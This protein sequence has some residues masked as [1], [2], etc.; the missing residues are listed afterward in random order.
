MS[1]ENWYRESAKEV[2]SLIMGGRK[3]PINKNAKDL[4][5]GEMGLLN[6]LAWNK[7]EFT[8]GKLSRYTGVGTG[9][10]ANL[11]NS[12]EKKGCVER[13][14][15]PEDRRSV[16]VSITDTGRAL[17]KEKQE[18][19]LSQTE[20]MLRMLGREDTEELIRIMHRITEMCG[21]ICC[22]TPASETRNYTERNPKTNA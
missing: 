14:M 20:S 8:A 16:I 5:F 3:N 11:L 17:V 21:D 18:E 9:G 10:I 15:N 4:S 7:E 6:I 19:V 12:L 22:G 13:T 1:E 2:L